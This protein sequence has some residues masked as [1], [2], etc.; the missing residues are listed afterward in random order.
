MN[1][2]DDCGYGRQFSSWY[3][4]VFPSDADAELTAAKLADLHPGR[5]SGTLE[6]GVG[7]GRIALPLSQRLGRV[8]GVDSSPE[9]LTLLADKA[10]RTGSDVVGVHGDIRLFDDGEL[11]DLVYCVCSTLALLLTPEEQQSAV[12]RAAGRL[13]PEGVL[14]L[15]VH[16]RP[17]VLALHASSASTTS[18]V[19]YP[20]PG[21]GLLTHATLSPGGT[22][23][24]CSHVWFEQ[25]GTSRVGSDVIR[26]SSSDELDARA[27]RA[28]LTLKAQWGD[29]QEAPLNDEAALDIRVYERAS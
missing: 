5:G 7:T 10:E 12:D 8:V 6:L 1:A 19:P 13:A 20:D 9:M 21:T 24:R 22:L 16:H 11:Y 28:G 25:D 26:L 2:I 29:W 14:V 3:D 4:R 27:A 17:A 18:F 15:E 23:W